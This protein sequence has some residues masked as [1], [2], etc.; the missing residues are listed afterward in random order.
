MKSPYHLFDGFGVE[1]E[2]MIVDKNTLQVKAIADELLKH[3]L[4]SIGSDYENGIVTWSNELVLHVIEIKSTKPEADLPSLEKAFAENVIRINK[5]LEKWNAMLLPTAAHPFMNPFTDTKLWPH[6]NNE[7]YALY[8]KLFDSKGHGWSNLQSTHL[9]LPF[10]GDEEFA[11]LHAAIRLILPL[12][13]ALCA[14]SP[15][16]DSNISGMLDTRLKFYKTNQAKIPVLTGSI[17]PEEVYSFEDY[18]KAIY[19]PIEKAIGPYDPDQILDPVWVNSRGAIARFD[20]GS[21]EIRVMD[22]QE[23]PAADLAIVTLVVETLKLLISENFTRLSEQKIIETEALANLFDRAAIRGLSSPV[24]DLSILAA[25]G[26]KTP[27]T[28][29]EIWKAILLKI[30]DSTNQSDYRKIIKSILE[31]GSLSERILHALENDSSLKNMET[32]YR[33]L[34]VCLQENKLFI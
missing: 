32:V 4:G 28:I 20:R 30:P 19:Q 12:L 17:I 8:D 1:L 7:V 25:F 11:K 9:N 29:K 16:L 13:P 23:C 10:H 3:E 24:E 33:R 21:I 26:L 2:Y 14:S 22:I 5:I 31:N 15:V 34:S 27:S 18:K 6:D